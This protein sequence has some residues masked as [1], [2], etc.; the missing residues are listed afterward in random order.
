[1]FLLTIFKYIFTYTCFFNLLSNTFFKVVKR[2]T[3]FWFQV[4]NKFLIYSEGI[5]PFP[6]IFPNDLH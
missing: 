6:R 4:T 3:L 5:V 1:M 2:Q